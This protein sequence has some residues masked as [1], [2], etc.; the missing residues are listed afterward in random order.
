MKGAPVPKTM[1]FLYIPELGTHPY[2]FEEPGQLIT[3]GSR[4]EVNPKELN[5]TRISF[6]IQEISKEILKEMCFESLKVDFGNVGCHRRCKLTFAI[7]TGL[8]FPKLNNVCFHVKVLQGKSQRILRLS[9]AS[10]FQTL[11][12]LETSSA[13]I[14]CQNAAREMLRSSCLILFWT[15]WSKFH[16]RKQKIAGSTRVVSQ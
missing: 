12:Q 6:Q 14:R 16:G 5:K 1:E 9:L 8:D 15:P 10:D 3:Q 13:T 7:H 11:W 2:C 4:L